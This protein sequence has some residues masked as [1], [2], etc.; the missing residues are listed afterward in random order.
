MERDPDLFISE[1][2]TDLDPKAQS[3]LDRIANLKEHD[4]EES[5]AT[6]LNVGGMIFCSFYPTLTVN[7][8]I[9]L[10][11]ENPKNLL[12]ELNYENTANFN[13]KVE[14][15][16]NNPTDSSRPF[17]REPHSPFSPFKAWTPRSKDNNENNGLDRKPEYSPFLQ[18]IFSLK[19]SPM[20]NKLFSGANNSAS[21][22]YE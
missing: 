16:N 18:D 22:D 11:I 9:G 8:A 6:H 12:E 20:Q 5:P 7:L 19:Y 3:K 10:P 4:K 17:S 1:N 21:K 13:D 14:M 2:R 15:G